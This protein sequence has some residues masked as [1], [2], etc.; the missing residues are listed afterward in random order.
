MRRK[1]FEFSSTSEELEQSASQN[2]R[3]VLFPTLQISYRKGAQPSTTSYEPSSITEERSQ[4]EEHS[5]D[6]VISVECIAQ[7]IR[8]SEADCQA[9]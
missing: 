6:S 7:V 1:E 9:N 4:D 5:S 8:L 3:Y 2:Q